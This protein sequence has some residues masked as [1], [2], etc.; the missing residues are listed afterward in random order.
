MKFLTAFLIICTVFTM[1][2]QELLPYREI[3]EAP[4]E[5]TATTVA[6]RM[7]DGLGFRYYWATEGLRSEDLLYKP[8][9]EARTSM[10]TVEHIYGLTKVI[11]NSVLKKPNTGAKDPDM[12]FEEMRSATLRNLKKS[13]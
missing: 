12:T 4:E 5:Y 11:L 8:S 7:V 13:E 2:S 3:Q 10:Q 1:N 9:S 6:S